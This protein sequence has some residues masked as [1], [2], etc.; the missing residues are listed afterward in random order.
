MRQYLEILGTPV[1]FSLGSEFNIGDSFTSVVDLCLLIIRK[2]HKCQKRAYVI[3]TSIR[4]TSGTEL[5][6][7][8]AQN[9]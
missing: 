6:V 7:G 9:F 4:V 5:G 2:R 1:P 8:I 3:C